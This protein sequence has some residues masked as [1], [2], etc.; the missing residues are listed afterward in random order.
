MTADGIA[1]TP[2]KQAERGNFLP[3]WRMWFR[4]RP[5]LA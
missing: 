5:C 1:R 2:E 4:R 3:A